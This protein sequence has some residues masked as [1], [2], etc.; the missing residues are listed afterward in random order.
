MNLVQLQ[1]QQKRLER[2]LANS[3]SQPTWRSGWVNRLARDLAETMAQIAALEVRT[4]AVA[5]AQA[6][7]ARAVRR[8][9]TA[10][11]P[12]GPAMMTPA[13]SQQVIR[14]ARG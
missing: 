4:D 8:F 10:A 2:E 9:A 11:R 6:S 1:G 12:I 7:S 5:Q 3:Y 14:H 13:S